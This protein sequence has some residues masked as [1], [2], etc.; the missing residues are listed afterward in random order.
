MIY[1]ICRTIIHVNNMKIAIIG[2]GPAG[3][4][5]AYFVRQHYPNVELTIIEKASQLG[6]RTTS[7]RKDGWVLDTGAGFVTNFYPRLFSI[8]QDHEFSHE[9][10]EMN[11]ISGL[12]RGGFVAP[13]NVG[14]TISFCSFHF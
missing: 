8:A 4:A 2:G 6:G 3:C 14:S 10:V 11:R 1:I 9:I 13:L 5:A 7:I 12:S